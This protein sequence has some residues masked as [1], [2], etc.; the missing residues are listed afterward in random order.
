VPRTGTDLGGALGA[1]APP[2]KFNHV[3]GRKLLEAAVHIFMHQHVWEMK[4]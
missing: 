2:P 3:Q 1:E 4:K